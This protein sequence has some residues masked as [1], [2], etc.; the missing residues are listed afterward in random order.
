MRLYNYGIAIVMG[1]LCLSACGPWL[2]ESVTDNGTVTTVSQLRLFNGDISG[3]VESSN[4]DSF[5]IYTGTELENPLDG[6]ADVYTGMGM[7]QAFI[8][9][10]E[11]PSPQRLIVYAMDFGSPAAATQMFAQEQGQMGATSIPIRGYDVATAFATSVS[12]GT[13]VTVYAHFDKFYLQLMLTGFSNQTDAMSK[14]YMFLH[15]FN[16]RWNGSI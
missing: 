4:A 8:Q 3:W 6:G 13:G 9:D 5:N 14:A 12:G 16:L 7:I 2:V 11:G 1:V 15:L 10:V